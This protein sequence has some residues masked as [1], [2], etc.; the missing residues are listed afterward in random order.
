MGFQPK[1]IIQKRILFSPLNWGLGHVS[2]SIP[3]LQKL[4]DQNNTIF[5]ACNEEQELIYRLYFKNLQ[6]IKHEGYPFHFKPNGFSIRYFICNIPK[7]WDFLK[8]EKEL[9][10]NW[11]H[12]KQIDFVLS[13]HRY[14]FRND[15]VHSI[16]ITHQCSL[17]LPWYMVIGQIIHKKLMGAFDSCWIVDDK[18]ERF[19]GKLSTTTHIKSF[20]LGIQSRFENFNLKTSKTKKTLLLS[21]PIIFHE[22]AL[23]YFLNQYPEI[24]TII[25]PKTKQSCLA[26]EVEFIDSSDW[27]AIDKILI[28]TQCLYSFSGYSTLMDVQ[29]LKCSWIC[30]P[31]P[32]QWEQQYLY[33]RKKP[34]EGLSH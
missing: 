10:K 1:D 11:V 29:F 3:L 14:G 9:V 31:T 5:V 25:G 28:E 4:A 12:S 21:G 24:D 2:R 20:Y 7:L 18:S 26:K 15:G 17:P 34:Q 6:F 13:D 30:I 19:A 8:K 33:K 32:G 16:F 23:N 27:I 22:F